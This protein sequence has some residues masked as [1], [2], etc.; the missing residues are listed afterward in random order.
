M[1]QAM[2]TGHE[3]SLSTCHANSPDDALRRLETM[4]LMGEVA[5]PLEAV[6]E[7]LG[8]ALD[9]V[10]Q[11][12]RRPGGVRAV[13]AVAEVRGPGDTSSHER[14]RALAGPSGVVALPK[15]PLRHPEAPPPDLR[16]VTEP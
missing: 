7:Q 3:G 9:L 12:S 6:R 1:L 5:L 2:N 14:T 10:V 8:A 13:V 16:W 15:R 4:V 11:V